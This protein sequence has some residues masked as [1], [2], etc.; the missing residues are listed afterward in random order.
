MLYMDVELQ[1]DTIVDDTW[2]TRWVMVG[3]IAWIYVAGAVE[4]SPFGCFYHALFA[5]QN[6]AKHLPFLDQCLQNA[7]Y[8][9]ILVCT[10]GRD[11]ESA[12]LYF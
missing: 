9:A 7:C 12:Y 4:T 8:I 6:T 2:P 10:V 5:L 1:S 3:Q 11:L